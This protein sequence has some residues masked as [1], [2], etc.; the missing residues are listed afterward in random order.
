MEFYVTQKRHISNVVVVFFVPNASCALILLLNPTHKHTYIYAM[1]WMYVKSN[2]TLSIR[3]SFAK[4]FSSEQDER[5]RASSRVIINSPNNSKNNNNHI[6]ISLM[7]KH[8]VCAV[9]MCALTRLLAPWSLILFHRLFFNKKSK[10]ICM[11]EINRHQWKKNL[12]V[13]FWPEHRV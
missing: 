10:L 4:L 3:S 12:L 13:E 11:I 6:I 8:K 7:E 1:P 5:A 2:S 9:G